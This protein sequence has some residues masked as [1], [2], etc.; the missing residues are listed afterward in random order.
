L[1]FRIASADWEIEQVHRLNYQAFVDEIPQHQPNAERRLVDKFHDQNTYVIGLDGDRLI[2]MLALRDQ[3]PFSLDYKLKDIDQYLPPFNKICEI[4]LLYILPGYRNA[5]VFRNLLDTAAS[6]GIPRGWD[7]GIIS[8]TTRQ[9][10][11]YQH[12]GFMPFGPLVGEPGAQ[13]QPMYWTLASFRDRLHWLQVLQ[14]ADL[15]RAS[16]Q[17]DAPVSIQKEIRTD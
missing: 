12:L 14:S 17:I 3:R 1:V 7:L 15:A 6:Y 11:L 4:R 9:L 5:A 10:R 8:G 13:F 2:A 16:D